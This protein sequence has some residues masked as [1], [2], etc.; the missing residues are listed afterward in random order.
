MQFITRRE[1]LRKSGLFLLGTAACTTFPA[2]GTG[3][4]QGEVDQKSVRD[5]MANNQDCGRVN[6]R[7]HVSALS[8][9]MT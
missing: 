3:C 1:A 7:P 9:P 6:C 2:F 8:I 4:S 5:L